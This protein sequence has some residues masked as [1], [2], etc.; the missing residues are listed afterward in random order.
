MLVIAL[1]AVLFPPAKWYRAIR[2][3]WTPRA[4]GRQAGDSSRGPGAAVQIIRT[5]LGGVF[6]QLS[7]QR[8]VTGGLLVV[9]F[10]VGAIGLPWLGASGW[11]WIV[12]IFG[13]ATA[14]VVSTGF[15]L[16]LSK[17][18]RG[19]IAELA[20]MPGLGAAA[21]QRRAL[22]RAV[23]AP[24]LPW[25]GAVVLLGSADLLLL[26]DEPLAGIGMLAVCL[27]ILWLTYAV[28]ALQM[29]ATLPPKRQNFISQFLLLYVIVYGA[30]NYYWVYAAH[31]QFRLWF[32]F[33]LT[34]VLLSVGI[35][36]AIGFSIR[37]LAAAPHP[38]LAYASVRQ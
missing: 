7:V 11:R 16:Q 27:L 28:L 21:A 30:G 20:L 5:S 13:L 12:I 9:L 37:R 22:C 29:L 31:P 34:P 32:W 2:R 33:W 15:L 35:V 14:G 25:L 6:L 26:G 3:G 24:P 17:L 4:S 8:L 18:T 1:A 38:F 36:S 19:Q 23:L 10:V